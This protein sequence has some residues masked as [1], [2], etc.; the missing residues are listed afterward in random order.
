LSFGVDYSSGGVDPVKLKAAG[1]SFVCR[2]VSTPGN[3]KNLTRVEAQGLRRAGLNIVTVFETTANRALKGRATGKTDALSAQAQALNCGA[4]TDVPIYFAVDFDATEHDQIAINAYLAGAAEALGKNRVGI[5]GGYWP[6][7]R[8][9]DAR[10]CHYGWQTYAWSGGHW[11]PRA[12]LRQYLNGQ[13]L[14]GTSVDFNHSMFP[15]FGQWLRP[16]PPPPAPV[17]IPVPTPIPPKP[18]PKPK[19]LP[20]PAKPW[21]TRYY[22]NPPPKFFRALREYRKRLG[23]S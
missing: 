23:K 4:P 9:L 22:K 11:D 15:D 1:V 19:P 20:V 16:K 2:Y 3:P 6:L 10:V 13:H 8:A 7:K 14:A 18:R 12:Q 21:W 5:Y 17:P